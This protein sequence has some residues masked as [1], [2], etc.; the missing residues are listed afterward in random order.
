MVPPTNESVGPSSP[1]SLS[2]VPPVSVPPARLVTL[3]ICNV[4]VL[5]STVPVLLS[6]TCN[7]EKPVSPVF[8]RR[9]A[10]VTIADAP[11]P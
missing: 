10:L 4:P 6:V 1:A 9:P 3:S 2:Q 11:A 8:S 7:S 5:S